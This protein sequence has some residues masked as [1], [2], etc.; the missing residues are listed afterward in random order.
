[1]NWLR[2]MVSMKKKTIQYEG[3]SIDLTY[4]TKRIIAAGFPAEGI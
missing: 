1:M 3:F 2:K 4:I